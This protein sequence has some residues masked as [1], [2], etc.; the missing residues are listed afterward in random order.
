MGDPKTVRVRIAVAVDAE[1]RY[2]AVAHQGCGD[3]DNRESAMEWMDI[4]PKAIGEHTTTYVQN[5]TVRHLY[6]IEADVPLP[7]EPTIEGEVV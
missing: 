2:A 1:G 3:K 7:T 5:P 6:F 4:V